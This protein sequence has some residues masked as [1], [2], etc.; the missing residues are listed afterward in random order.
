MDKKSKVL[1]YKVVNTNIDKKFIGD[2]SNIN[3]D[4]VVILNSNEREKPYVNMIKIVDG[5]DKFIKIN[6]N[7]TIFLATPIYEGREKTF[8]GLLDKIAMAGATSITLPP[9]EYLSYQYITVLLYHIFFAMS[10]KF[11]SFLIIK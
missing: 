10:M 8:Y 7:D 2:L 11:L 3:D 1:K 5:Y 6:K 4:N 9:K